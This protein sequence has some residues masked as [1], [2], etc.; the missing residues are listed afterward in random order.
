L[1][2]LVGGKTNKEIAD[3]LT[4]STVTVRGYVSSILSKLRASNRTEA[5][6]LALQHNLIS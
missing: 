1:A 2:L 3:K 5:V 4:L 6:S